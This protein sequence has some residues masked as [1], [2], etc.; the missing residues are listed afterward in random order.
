M[1]RRHSDRSRVASR[2]IIVSVIVL[3]LAGAVLIQYALDNT[4]ARAGWKDSSPYDA[5]RSILDVLGGVRQTIAA[6]WWTRT[7]VL[8]HEYFGHDLT[9][10]T[11][12]FPYEWLITKLDPHFAIAYYFASYTLC[13]MGLVDQGF[14]LALEGVRNNPNSPELQENLAEIYFFYKR[15]A[16][17]ALYHVNKA[18]QLAQTYGSGYFITADFT[19]FRDTIEAAIAGKIKIP[20]LSSLETLKAQARKLGE[21]SEKMES[22]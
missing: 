8:F 22:H 11:L 17:K 5:T 7:D 3:I 4:T 16:R 12:D 10:E 6:Y 14:N 18:I 2:V 13:R 15:D 21:E 1:G 9:K 20:P 19:T